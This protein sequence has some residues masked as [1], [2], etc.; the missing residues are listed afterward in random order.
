MR[1]QLAWLLTVGAFGL[2]VQIAM[3]SGAVTRVVDQTR[4]VYI[5]ATDASGAAVTDLTATDLVLK[6]GGKERQVTNVQPATAA[7]QVVII[8]DDRGTGFFQLGVAK[9]IQQLL[10]HAD[11]SVRLINNQAMKLVDFTKDVDALKGA[12]SHLTPR[13]TVQPDGDQLL[14]AISDAARDLQKIKSER[15]VIVVVTGGGEAAKALLPA[16]VLD[17]LKNSGASLH[18]L[19]VT[20]AGIG[21]VLGDGPRQSGGRSDQVGAATGIADG[22]ERIGDGL[23]HQYVIS[24]TLPTGVKPNEKLSVSVTRKGVTLLAPIRVRDK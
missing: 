23:M 8:D 14:E 4:T 18:V 17:Q 19:S 15:P 10:G 2:G 1:R 11:F 6:E 21:Q 9:F 7:M 16:D 5:S 13:G 20:G 24:Y 12:I 22:M 3:A